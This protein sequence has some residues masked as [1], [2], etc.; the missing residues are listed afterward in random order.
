MSTLARTSLLAKVPS[1]SSR[2]TGDCITIKDNGFKLGPNR[3]KMNPTLLTPKQGDITRSETP[4]GRS[5]RT[6]RSPVNTPRPELS[7]QDN[8]RDQ[9]SGTSKTAQET[10][11][12]S[13]RLTHEDVS[14]QTSP[15]L[16]YIQK[17][18]RSEEES[19]EKCK[20]VLRK[21]RQAIAKQK[22]I[23]MDVKNG[24][25]ELEELLD[26]TG[27]YRRNWKSAERERKISERNV[28]EI[29]GKLTNGGSTAT[30]TISQNKRSASSPAGTRPG[31]KPKE[32][33]P[34]RTEAVL[35]EEPPLLETRSEPT[36]TKS[37]N[38]GTG[39]KRRQTKPKERP[40][41][42][43]IR[44]T[45]GNSFADVLKNLRNKVKPE[46]TEVA[47]RSIRKTKMGAILLELGKGGKKSDFCDAIK[48]AL[49]D[50]ADVK[51]VKPKVNL[52]IRDLDFFSTKEEVLA[53]IERETD[54]EGEEIV[55]HVT[56]ADS[57]EQ[58]RAFVTLP[59]ASA[60]ILLKTQR[61]KIGWTRCRIRYREEIKRCYRC[62]GTGHMQWECNGL[63]R[64]GI[65]MC[66][67]C[68]ETGH[69]MK[70]CKNPRK[71]CLC[72]QDGKT[73]LD[74]L[75]GTRSCKSNKEKAR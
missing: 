75:P 64:K 5:S 28:D 67:R 2:K 55:V 43:I 66:I 41:A 49:K 74:H 60:N 56:E 50:A 11:I 70:E 51:D 27:D 52:E 39:G 6:L 40:E 17:M 31:K 19:L 20:N 23:S 10:P 72:S 65:G 69:K 42:V 8:T 21:I 22:N 71:C 1:G 18:K 7:T 48:G 59:A 32:R 38:K 34:E 12:E 3:K 33:A 25:S 37:K 36:T 63:D 9:N 15:R 61:I 68:G 35:I 24:V 29:T 16:E 53:S 54:A 4:F 26:V 44:P 58:R 62:F 13:E 14:A 73:T 47:V 46:E 45:E 30:P 57:R